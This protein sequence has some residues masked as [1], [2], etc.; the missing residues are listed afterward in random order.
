MHIMN[1]RYSTSEELKNVLSNRGLGINVNKSLYEELIVP[2]A[3]QG[4]EARGMRSDVR[5]KMNVLE[6]MCSCSYMCEGQEWPEL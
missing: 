4:A 2:M 1:E 6:M 3:L 5:R